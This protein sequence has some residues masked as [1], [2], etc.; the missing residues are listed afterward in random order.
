VE[1]Q[2]PWS[3]A[4][5]HCDQHYQGLA[6]I[7]NADDQLVLNNLLGIHNQSGFVWIGGRAWQTSRWPYRGWY[8]F[9]A[10]T[11]IPFSFQNY[12]NWEATSEPEPEYG[13]CV[14]AYG[15][16][17]GQEN[18]G[19]WFSEVCGTLAP[20][21]CKRSHGEDPDALQTGFSGII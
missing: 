16:E 4:K 5:A 11:V 10:N 1:H 13:K 19:K 21:V 3:E 6:A 14:Y 20:F 9:S 7:Y 15:V 18:L 17:N 2:L 8:W 12:R